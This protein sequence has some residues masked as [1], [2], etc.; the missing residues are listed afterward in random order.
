MPCVNPD[1]VELRYHGAEASPLYERQMRMSGGDFSTWQSNA[2]GVDLNH[3]Y[4]FAFHEYSE[5]SRRMGIVAGATLFGGE[6]P[7]SEPETKGIAN[8]VRTLA[9]SAVVSLHSQGEEIYSFP[10]TARIK[11][12]AGRLSEL[13]G[14]ASN[15][16]IGTAAY[17]GLCDYTASL[18]IPSFTFEVGKGKNPLPESSSPDIFA[19]VG[20]AIALLPTL[21]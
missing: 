2:R 13:T 18:G 14:Y 7:E 1:G 15:T 16:P 9:P 8:L 17:S 6:Y 11:R 19:R 5:I 4:D 12:I 3:N 21:L 10:N 20:R